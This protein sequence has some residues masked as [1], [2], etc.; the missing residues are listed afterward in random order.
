[1]VVVELVA[2]GIARLL[3][4]GERG[5]PLVGRGGPLQHARLA[6]A[7]VAVLDLHP[8]EFVAGARELPAAE[9]EVTADGRVLARIVAR[10]GLDVDDPVAVAVQ[11]R[12]RVGAGAR[13]RTLRRAGGPQPDTVSGAVTDPVVAVVDAER[14]VPVVGRL[15]CGCEARTDLGRRR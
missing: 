5:A 15:A 9:L 3:R 4:E 7:V 11:S 6:V 2:R 13:G 12:V 8:E 14:G 10:G 1:V